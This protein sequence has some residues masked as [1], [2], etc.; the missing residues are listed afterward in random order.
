MSDGSSMYYTIWEM[1]LWLIRWTLLSTQILLATPI[2]LCFVIQKTLDEEMYDLRLINRQINVLRRSSRSASAIDFQKSCGMISRVVDEH[3]KCLK[4][5]EWRIMW[6]GPHL[7]WM[8][9]GIKEGKNY[10]KFRVGVTYSRGVVMFDSL[11]QTMSGWGLLLVIGGNRNITS[12][13][14]YGRLQL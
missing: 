1:Y 4:K 10:A 2:Q 12:V 11:Q 6:A 3:A 14:S 5:K 8:A 7:S 13:S 9:R